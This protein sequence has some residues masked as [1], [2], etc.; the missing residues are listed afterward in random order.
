MRRLYLLRHS[1]SSWKDTSL[2]D[3]DRPLNKRGY[4][5]SKQMANYIK[6]QDYYPEVILC[7]TAKRT[8]ETLDPILK[9]IKYDKE[10]VFMDSIYESHWTRLKKEVDKR[11]ESSIMLIGHCPGVE[12][13][14]SHLLGEDKIMKTSQLAV[15]DI[16]DDKAELIDFIRPKE[17]K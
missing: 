11:E 1:K 6:E 2:I 9:E 15:V 13:Y 7:S 14:L 10:V 3:F 8:R 12:L 17:F 16:E 5:E 4:R